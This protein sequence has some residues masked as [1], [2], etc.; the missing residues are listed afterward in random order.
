[1]KKGNPAKADIDARVRASLV[2]LDKVGKFTDRRLTP[3]EQAID[4]PEH[5]ALI[6]ESGAAGIVLLKNELQLLRIDTEKTKRIAFLGPLANQASAHGGGSSFL[7]YHYKTS[8]VEA[9][10]KRVGS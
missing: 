6:Q 7:A 8:P 2:L 10:T 3:E 4:L 5:R 1:M 9:F